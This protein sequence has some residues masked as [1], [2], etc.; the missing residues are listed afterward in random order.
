VTSCGYLSFILIADASVAALAWIYVMAGSG[1]FF[2]TCCC[3][4]LV[5]FEIKKGRRRRVLIQQFDVFP[6]CVH[7]R[8]AARVQLVGHFRR[9]KA[10]KTLQA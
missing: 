10:T 9:Y 3:F 8:R 6:T 7:F 4:R 2:M 1:E 5:S